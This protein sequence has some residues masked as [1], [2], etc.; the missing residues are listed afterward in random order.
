MNC[1]WCGNE[2]EGEFCK[3]TTCSYESM[4]FNKE[5]KRIERR[6]WVSSLIKERD[7]A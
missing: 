3:G 2:S 1:R 7:A 6:Q 4:K 5:K